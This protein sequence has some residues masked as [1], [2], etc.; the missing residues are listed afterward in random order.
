MSR[1]LAVCLLIGVAIAIFGGFA[2]FVSLAM[3][4]VALRAGLLLDPL[5]ALGLSI[6]LCAAGLVWWLRQEIVLSVKEEWEMWRR[7]RR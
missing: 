4:A 5:S 6:G 7:R 1:V 3:Q 2:A